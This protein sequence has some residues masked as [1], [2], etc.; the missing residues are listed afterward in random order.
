MY[1]LPSLIS[2][3]LW[4]TSHKGGSSGGAPPNMLLY[5]WNHCSLSRGMSSSVRGLVVQMPASL[6]AF[7]KV[8]S[9]R[10][11]FGV[12]FLLFSL[13]S[14]AVPMQVLELSC[15]SPAGTGSQSH[16]GQPLTG[17]LTQVACAVTVSES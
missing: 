12:L 16:W 6:L 10:V 14:P 15:P 9:S 7:V 2:G 8:V 17:R 3:I 4:F 11:S 13:P 1:L 5:L